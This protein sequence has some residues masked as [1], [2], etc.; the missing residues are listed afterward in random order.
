[1]RAVPVAVVEDEKLAAEADNVGKK[2]DQRLAPHLQIIFDAALSP[3]RGPGAIRSIRSG[4]D[5]LLKWLL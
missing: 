5:P 3:L 4:C 2:V 1:M